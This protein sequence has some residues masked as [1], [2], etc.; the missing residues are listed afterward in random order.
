MGIVAPELVVGKWVVGTGLTG[1]LVMVCGV[2]VVVGDVVPTSV[3][4]SPVWVVGVGLVSVV[5]VETIIVLAI[6][7]I[8]SWRKWSNNCQCRRNN[9]TPRQKHL[10]G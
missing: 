4:L 2:V 8:S 7:M 1:V 5:P 6:Q 9:C 3:S 10:S